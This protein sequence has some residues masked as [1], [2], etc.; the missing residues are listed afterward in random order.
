[1]AVKSHPH[2]NFHIYGRAHWT[3][4]GIIPYN[5]KYDQTE[6]E[7]F[8][9]K[10]THCESEWTLGKGVSSPSKC[11]FCGEP[12]TP[13]SDTMEAVL[14]YIAEIYGADILRDSNKLI[15]YF[16]DVAPKLTRERNLLRSFTQCN[17]N[18]RLLKALSLSDAER[19]QAWFRLTQDL[20]DEMW[21]DSNAISLVCESFWNVASDGKIPAPVPAQPSARPQTPAKPTT[22]QKVKTIKIAGK[23]IQTD[24]TELV[25]TSYYHSID[26]SPV[27][28]LFQLTFLD[29]SMCY[30]LNDIRPL[31]SLSQLEM[32]NLSFCERLTD[33]RPLS[34]LSQ[35]KT[36]DLSFCGR[37]TDLRPLSSLSQL[38]TLNLRRCDNLTSTEIN[39][40]K[41]ALPKCMIET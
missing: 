25:L 11:P 17:G 1:L 31:S 36:L 28:D 38:K 34:S 41:K 22:P 27:S 2:E 6:N 20:K 26:I 35:L 14:K 19:R 30:Y 37:L 40:L 5:K 7:G 24:V 3:K 12:L 13:E 23:T 4:R 39:K 9:L 33:L 21:L 29:L 10:C 32:L 18:T 16:A 8:L 15:A